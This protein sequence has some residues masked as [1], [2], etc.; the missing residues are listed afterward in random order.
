MMQFF[1]TYQPVLDH[2]LLSLGFAFSQWVVLRAGVFSVA[3]AGLAAIGGYSAALL[4]LDGGLP[5]FVTILLGAVLGGL[6]GVALAWPLA[7][8]RGVYQAIASLAFVQ[9]VLSLN[10][11]AEGITRGAL[12]VDGIPKLVETPLLLLLS[13]GLIYLMHSVNTYRLGRT[14]E[15]VRQD[16][17]VA[18][19]L[20]ISTIHFQTI[21]FAIGGVIAGLYGGLTAFHSY[22]LDPAQFGFEFL[23]AALSFVILGGRR[24][25]VGPVIGTAVLVI[26]PELS[27]EFGEFRQL[28]YGVILMI[29]I[30]FMPQGIADTYLS[31]SR[32]KRLASQQEAQ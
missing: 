18:N 11:Y 32:K 7:R 9:I 2:G 8:L 31:W 27:R 3:S 19:S 4:H 1:L 5:P 17:A 28:G 12:G 10:L 30:V 26:L 21:A 16:E 13:A 6:F 25:V 24:S 29:V 20:G 23:V 15:T 14:F 22:H